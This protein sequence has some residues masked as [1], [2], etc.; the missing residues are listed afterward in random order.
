MLNRMV[1]PS[2]LLPLLLG[3]ASASPAVRD[4]RVPSSTAASPSAA[5]RRAERPP[6]TAR[7]QALR[8]ELERDVGHLASQVGERHS[9]KPWEFAGAADWIATEFESSGLGVARAGVE[10]GDAVAMDIEA[11]QRGGRLGREVVIVSAHYDSHPGSVGADD[12]ATGVA[13]LLALGRAS[14]SAHPSRTLRLVATAVTGSSAH[15][16]RVGARADAVYAALNLESLGYYSDQPGSQRCP[17]A[18]VERCPSA[19]DFAAVVAAERSRT[20][21]ELVTR[22]LG[23]RTSLPV[24]G[25]L[26]DPGKRQDFLSDA[27]AVAEIGFPVLT[28]TDTGA[29]R[30]PNHHA[31]GDTPDRID[32]DRL[33]RLV[34]GLEEVVRELGGEPALEPPSPGKSSAEKS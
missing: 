11:T 2:A 12:K 9:G 31:A 34:A 13:A 22:I 14:R 6:L 5:A 10:A 15:A 20:M 1:A 3:C 25:F 7:E 18:F 24:R 17:G 21:F 16:K 27:S 33:A 28:V 32:F 19:G 29:W 26:L 23:Q 8:A 30:N 4:G